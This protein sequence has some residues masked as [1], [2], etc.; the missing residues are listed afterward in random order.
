MIINFIC[1]C[2]TIVVNQKKKKLHN[3]RMNSCNLQ[4]NHF[5][6]YYHVQSE[7]KTHVIL[8]SYLWLILVSDLRTK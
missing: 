5:H 8:I 1:L 2:I 7:N 3:L 4:L 6:S